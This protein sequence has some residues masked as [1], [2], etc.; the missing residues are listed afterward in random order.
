MESGNQSSKPQIMAHFSNRGRVITCCR[1]GKKKWY[2]YYKLQKHDY[3]SKLSTQKT[4]LLRPAES[5]RLLYLQDV[6]V[7]YHAL[8]IVPSSN[9]MGTRKT[10]IHQFQTWT[11][12]T[13]PL[14]SQ[15]HT[16][17]PIEFPVRITSIL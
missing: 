2:Q 6:T 16:T 17:T 11:T 9:K 7:L 12:H 3:I 13:P 1:G 10:C 4:S 15:E 5:Q 8:A 14:G